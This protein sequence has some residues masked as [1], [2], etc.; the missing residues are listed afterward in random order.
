M[1]INDTTSGNIDDAGTLLDLAKGVII[2]HALQQ[3]KSYM[4]SQD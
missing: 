3:Q 2:E 4:L 1:V